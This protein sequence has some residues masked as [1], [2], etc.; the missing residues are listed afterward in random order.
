M[1]L[2]SSGMCTMAVL[3]VAMV[4]VG[5]FVLQLDNSFLQF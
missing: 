1:V 4:W 2:K 5:I 3:E